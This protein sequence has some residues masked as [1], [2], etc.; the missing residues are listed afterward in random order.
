MNVKINHKM[1]LGLFVLVVAGVYFFRSDL[2]NLLYNAED[3]NEEVAITDTTQNITDDSEQEVGQEEAAPITPEESTEETALP[4]LAMIA[5][6]PFTSQ[7]PFGD[8]ADPKQQHGCE[9]ASLLMAHYWMQ[10]KKL[11]KE[12]ALTEIFSMSEYEEKNYGLVYDLSI[13]DTLKFWREYYG[14]KKSFTKYD[15]SAEDIK[16]EIAAGNPVIVPMDGTKL[17]NPQ[18]TA[19][20]PERHEL[21]VIGYD[22]G[23]LEFIT[24][25]P[26]TR[27]GEGYRYDYEIFMGAIRDY[28][29]GFDEPIDGIVKA[30]LVVEKE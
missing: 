13:A 24:N 7:A 25:D 11:T 30:I 8:W 23:A 9:E 19:P 27:F 16:K 4:P 10:G 12:T 5:G 21:I 20:G 3:I 15:I 28:K 26:G 1:A 18:Y 29:T 2:E 14:Y 6:V 22:D 17:G